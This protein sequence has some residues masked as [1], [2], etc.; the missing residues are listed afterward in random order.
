M[1]FGVGLLV[2]LKPFTMAKQVFEALLLKTA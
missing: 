1:E 2:F